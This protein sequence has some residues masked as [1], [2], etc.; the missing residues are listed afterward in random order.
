MEGVPGRSWGLGGFGG[1]AYLVR[2]ELEPI[3]APP[4]S[5]SSP[6][7]P[8]TC[9]SFGKIIVRVNSTK[10]LSRPIHSERERSIQRVS[11]G[12]VRIPF[13][14]Q[15]FTQGEE[16][17]CLLWITQR[18]FLKANRL[19]LPFQFPAKQRRPRQLGIDPHRP[20][21]IVHVL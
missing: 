19:A 2:F 11:S 21:E 18:H 7:G 16:L 15:V 13:L 10:L 4:P 5:P 9:H 1:G 12:H 8:M 3:W 20:G 14:V 17:T 6:P